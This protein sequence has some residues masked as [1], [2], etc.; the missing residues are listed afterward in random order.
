[1]FA[2]THINAQS[3]AKTVYV[4]LASGVKTAPAFLGFLKNVTSWVGWGGDVDVRE[5]LQHIRML[6]NFLGWVEHGPLWGRLT[7]WRDVTWR[8]G[9]L[10]CPR[11]VLTWRDVTASLPTAAP[12][13]PWR[14]VT[15]R[16]PCLRRRLWRPDVTW[17][18][19]TWR[20]PCPRRRCDVLTWRDVTWRPPCRRQR[21]HVTSWRDVTACKYF[22][23][24]ARRPDVK[25]VRKQST[26]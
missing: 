5:N 3:A 25:S 10:T 2:H 22:H 23:G 9:I 8:P 14:D 17:R 7:S 1:M 26:A 11:D 6:R 16:P 15:W 12:V 24:T 4:V 19:V 18:D 13:T 21:L 20:P